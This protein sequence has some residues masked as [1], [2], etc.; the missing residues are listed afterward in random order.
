MTLAE[1]MLTD[2]S[3]VFL[4]RDDFA[5]AIVYVS[6]SGHR[7]TIT[8][9]VVRGESFA[10]EGFATGETIPLTATLELATYDADTTNGIDRAR[11][12]GKAVGLGGDYFEFDGKR[13]NPVASPAGDA[14]M[15]QLTVKRAEDVGHS[16]QGFRG[17]LQ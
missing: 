16:R 14:A 7:R 15:F 9:V 2:A 10:V 3:A 8:A 5:E 4:N 13:W 12:Q 6:A 11:Y 17:G 1:Q